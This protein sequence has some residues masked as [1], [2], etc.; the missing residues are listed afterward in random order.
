MQDAAAVRLLSIIAL[1]LYREG[2]AP[3]IFIEQNDP[4]RLTAAEYAADTAHSGIDQVDLLAI[5]SRVGAEVLD[6]P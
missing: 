3:A 2:T 6:F 5:W 1:D 4:L